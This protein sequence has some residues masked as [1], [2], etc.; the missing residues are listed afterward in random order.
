V[1]EARRLKALE[2]ENAK[3]RKL[4]A[5]LLLESCHPEGRG[6]QEIW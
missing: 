3:V 5:E 6:G 2:D 1:S 4:L